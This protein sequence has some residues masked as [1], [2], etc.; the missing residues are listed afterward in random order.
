MQPNVSGLQA[1]PSATSLLRHNQQPAL[2][3]D[4]VVNT[5]INEGDPKGSH[6]AQASKQSG[7]F[8]IFAPKSNCLG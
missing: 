2:A 1:G 5:E 4:S 3:E 7:M 8:S 6:F